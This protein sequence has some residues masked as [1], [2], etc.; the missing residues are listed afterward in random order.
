MNAQLLQVITES[1]AARAH[2]EKAL[3][4]SQSNQWV[5]AS[6]GQANLDEAEAKARAGC[7]E[8][9]KQPCRIVLRNFEPVKAP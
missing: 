1:E 8:R 9:A 7:E 6:Y 3:A 2:L 4:V 5:Y